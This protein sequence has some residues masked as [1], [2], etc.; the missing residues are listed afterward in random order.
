MTAGDSGPRSGDGTTRPG[1]L[2]RA[3][4]IYCLASAR[5]APPRWIAPFA[6]LSKVAGRPP[7]DANLR[8]AL[9]IARGF[10]RIYDDARMSFAEQF[11]RSIQ[12]TRNQLARSISSV[13]IV[14]GRKPARTPRSGRAVAARSWPRIATGSRLRADHRAARS[15]PL[16]VVQPFLSLL[17]LTRARFGPTCAL[18][19]S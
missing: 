7:T 4:R 17:H 16:S 1:Y 19:G 8:P 15:G 18:P 12:G 10:F 6:G 9:R 5:S 13:A 14:L 11:Q 2:L 3:R